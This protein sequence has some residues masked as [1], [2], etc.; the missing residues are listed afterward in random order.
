VLGTDE[1]NLWLARALFDLGGISFGD[2][3]LGRTAVNSPIYVNPRVL[4]SQPEALRRVARLIENEV[5][6]GQAR[7]RKAI[8][9]F[10]LVA[11]VPFGGLHLATA[12]SLHSDVP[13]IYARPGDGSGSQAPNGHPS[14]RI[15]GR[16]VPG[17]RVL[18][19]D[20]LITGG[21][22][23]L[24][25]ARRLAEVGLQVRDAIVLVDRQQGADERLHL[26]GINLLSI[27]RLK[28]MLNFYHE[29]GLIES[30]WYD[31]SMEYLEQQSGE[32][33]T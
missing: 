10:S 16:Y 2:F 4:I 25:A 24:E 8:S 15:E 6:A 9:P 12:F 13:L 3:T 7:R 17:Q 1:T 5:R 33:E 14:S 21:G 18:V 28:T 20:D 30:T 22:S 29:T 11:G 26:N 27:L 31:R 19:V 23:V 32:Q